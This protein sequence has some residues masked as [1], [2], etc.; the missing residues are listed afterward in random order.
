MNTIQYLMLGM[1]AISIVG[2]P[3]LLA[4]ATRRRQYY[5]LFEIPLAAAVVCYIAVSNVWPSAVHNAPPLVHWLL[6]VLLVLWIMDL[7]GF[8]RWLFSR[9]KRTQQI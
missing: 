9:N 6:L 1:S 5:R 4:K 3:F 7:L 8:F 2:T